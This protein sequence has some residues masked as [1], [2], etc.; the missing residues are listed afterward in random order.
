[1]KILWKGTLTKENYFPIGEPVPKRPQ[2]HTAIAVGLPRLRLALPN[3]RSQRFISVR[4]VF[5]L[6]PII[7]TASGYLEKLTHDRYR[8]CIC[9][10]RLI[11]YGWPYRLPAARRKE[12]NNSFSILIRLFS[13]LYSCK[14]SAAFR[15]CVVRGACRLRSFELLSG[16]NN[17]SNGVLWQ[18]AVAFLWIRVSTPR[19]PP[20]HR[21]RCGCRDPTAA[22]S[23]RRL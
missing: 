2:P 12:C 18:D 20:A 19:P 22:G 11:L 3:Q 5:P 7:V 16:R 17:K 4:L 9:F 14:L 10:N 13:Y 21:S 23:R 6:P 1:M 15:P 8:P